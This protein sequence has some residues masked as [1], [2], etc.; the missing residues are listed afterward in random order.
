MKPDA[1]VTNIFIFRAK[2]RLFFHIKKEKG[3]NNGK[4]DRKW[5]MESGG[6]TMENGEWIMDN[7]E[8]RRLETTKKSASGVRRRF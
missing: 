8:F 2:V 1:P 4:W 3:K 6:A 5:R 7:E